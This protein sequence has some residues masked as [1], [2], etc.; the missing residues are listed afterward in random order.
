MK[1]KLCVCFPPLST[2][3]QLPH[4]KYADVGGPTKIMD[5]FLR[6]TAAYGTGCSVAKR[7]YIKPVYYP[8]FHYTDTYECVVK[9]MCTLYV[10]SSI[11]TES[12]VI[13]ASEVT[14]CE[15]YEPETVN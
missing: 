7:R 9:C 10:Y 6:H 2:Y 1:F 14:I 13:Y 5:A 3:E 11:W 12:T 8:D 15:W 4:R